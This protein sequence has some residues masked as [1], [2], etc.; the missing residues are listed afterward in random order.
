MLRPAKERFL[1]SLVVNWTAQEIIDSSEDFQNYILNKEQAGIWGRIAVP[2][3]FMN[4]YADADYQF[5]PLNPSNLV[6]SSVE[7]LE[8]VKLTFAAL[9]SDNVLVDNP[10]NDYLLEL[11]KETQHLNVSEGL[12]FLEGKSQCIAS[13]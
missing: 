3:G 10:R 6:F 13:Q 9:I 4:I 7:A 8:I 2:D 11:A 12:T 1:I 5:L